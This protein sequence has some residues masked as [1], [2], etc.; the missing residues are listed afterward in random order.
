M[1]AGILYLGSGKLGRRGP[2]DG[3]RLLLHAAALFRGLSWT[4][5]GSLGSRLV[6][7]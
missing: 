3:Y 2:G 5:S 7:L 6:D 4:Q 1:Q